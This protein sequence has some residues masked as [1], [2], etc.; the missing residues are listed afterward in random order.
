MVLL[1]INAR[2]VKMLNGSVK[3]KF[4]KGDKVKV[5]KN[6]PYKAIWNIK[7]GDTGIVTDASDYGHVVAVCVIID[8][9]KDDLAPLHCF[10]ERE[11]EKMVVT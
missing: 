11:L 8:H 5:I 2:N 7:I 6:D 1:F 3:M 4:K 10:D 9:L